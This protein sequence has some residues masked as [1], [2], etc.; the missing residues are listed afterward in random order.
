MG[1]VKCLPGE[2]SREGGLVMPDFDPFLRPPPD[3]DVFDLFRSVN[4]APGATQTLAEFILGRN[5]FARISNLGQEI[6]DDPAGT[7][8]TGF[9]NTVWRIV[10]NSANDRF[11]GDIR[12]QIGRGD[13][14]S[15]IFIRLSE[16]G[17]R[18]LFQATNNH[19][20]LTFLTFGRLRGW[21][22]PLSSVR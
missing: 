19:A 10:I 1:L 21:T 4:I 7:A 5:E 22:I 18:V 20:T 9:A 12:D 3:A 2:R 16:P 15:E 14:P 13:Q 6:L 11:F 8:V 17:A